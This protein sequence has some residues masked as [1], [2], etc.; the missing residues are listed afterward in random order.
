MK[1]K[2]FTLI[3][4]LVKRSHL[5]C[6]RVYGKEGSFSPAHG[7]VKLYSFTLIE[8]L[9]VIAI[10]AILAAM[11]LP[12][13]NKAREKAKEVQCISNSK[14]IGTGLIAY[15]TDNADF[16]P[17]IANSNTKTRL[18]TYIAPYTG[19]PITSSKPDGFWFCPS[20]KPVSVTAADDMYSSS[21]INVTGSHLPGY[22]WYAWPADAF[23]K[24]QKIS[25]L[26]PNVLLLTSRQP[27]Y[28]SWN[29]L[30]V[31]TDPIYA[32]MLNSTNADPLKDYPTVLYVHSGRTN[33]FTVSGNVLVHKR[34]TAN[35]AQYMKIDDTVK[36]YQAVITD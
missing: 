15:T 22:D 33:F 12:A 24:T 14:Q 10:I 5:C 11:L 3:E 19:S 32:H 21:Y 13:L 28:L 1:S 23:T 26:D 29:K 4:L 34:P 27:D 31:S 17:P 16:L 35:V 2:H 8:L 18:R 25:R 9:V 20:H 7:Q 6:D 36:G 30:V